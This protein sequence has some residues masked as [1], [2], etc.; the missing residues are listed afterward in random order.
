MRQRGEVA[1]VA[2]LTQHLVDEGDADAE[3]LGDLR[4]SALPSLIGSDDA[5]AQV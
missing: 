4:D 2:P 3:L 1:C 5:L